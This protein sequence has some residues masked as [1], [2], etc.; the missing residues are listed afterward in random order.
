MKLCKDCKWYDY[1]ACTVHG[2][3]KS[4]IDGK[5]R[6]LN[7]EAM[8][9]LDVD[10]ACGIEAKHFEPKPKPWWKVWGR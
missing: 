4:V 1:G 9:R 2:K 10:G 3:R 7:P 5:E 8:R 6:W